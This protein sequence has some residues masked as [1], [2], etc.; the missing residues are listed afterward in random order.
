MIIKKNNLIKTFFND[1]LIWFQKATTFSKLLF[2]IYILSIFD[3]ICDLRFGVKAAFWWRR[4][5]RCATVPYWVIPWRQA[6][7]QGKLLLAEVLNSATVN[8]ACVDIR[9]IVKA[10]MGICWVSH[11][12]SV[13]SP[14]GWRIPSFGVASYWKCACSA[15]RAAKRKLFCP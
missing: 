11:R 13:I 14:V 7:A 6:L 9:E 4:V 15:P 8:S 2:L 3:W 1:I 5:H 12:S 10:S